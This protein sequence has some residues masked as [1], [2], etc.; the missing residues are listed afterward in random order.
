E[1]LEQPVSQFIVRQLVDTH[2]GAPNGSRCSSAARSSLAHATACDRFANRRLRRR[3]RFLK[4]CTS[5]P[6]VALRLPR[7]GP[8]MGA[9]VEG[10]QLDGNAHT[11][12]PRL[13]GVKT[14]SIAIVSHGSTP[15]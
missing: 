6:Q 14:V 10:A 3:F 5:I 12:R 1:A 8:P 11:R 13:S 7:S 9:P 2:R 15:G 4:M